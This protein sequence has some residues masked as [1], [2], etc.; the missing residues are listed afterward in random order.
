MLGFFSAK[1]DHP[2]ADAKEARRVMAELPSLDPGTAV[3]QATAWFESLAASTDF[4][5]DLRLERLFQLDEAALPQARRLAREYLGVARSAR[6]QEFKLWQANRDY[7]VE[8][9]AAYEK[10]LAGVAAGEKGS[11]PIKTGSMG[12]KAGTGLGLLYARL[13]GAY[14]GQSKWNQL[15]YE[16]SDGSLWLAAGRIYLAAAADK[17]AQRSVAL[18]AGRET[19]PEA[20]Y[21][22]L[23]VFH[24]ASMDKLL[25]LEIEVAEHLIAHFLPYFV[26][27]AEVRPDNVYWVDAAKPLPPTRLVKLPG[28]S[29]TLRFFSTG[30]A[31]DAVADLRLDVAARQALPAAIV[32]GG[33]YAVATVLTVLDHL[34]MCW[35]PQPP[36]RSHPRHRVESRL[37]VVCGLAALHERLASLSFSMAGIESWIVA[38]VSQG[39]MG[40]LIP[41]LTRDC[42]GIGTLVGMQPEGGDNWLVGVI[43]R[44]SRESETQGAVGIETLSKSPRAIVADSGGLQTEGILLEPPATGTIVRVLLPESAW[45]DDIALTLTL[46]GAR[47]RLQPAGLIESGNGFALGRYT[48]SNA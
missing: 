22:K 23:L 13:L 19:T 7:W 28:M 41:K 44:F 27:T 43:R 31:A 30:K 33:Q 10:C 32:L 20:E 14:A 38:D 25:P 36:M 45:E 1:P 8:L 5:P 6:A 47:V 17:L 15:H 11:E 40:A 18:S 9:A 12:A 29:P 34:A 37:M 35:S 39:G 21:L 2:L 42:A 24:A 16:P 4:R 48:V 26:F 46:D 3:D